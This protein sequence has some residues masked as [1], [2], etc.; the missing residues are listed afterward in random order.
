[1]E[2]HTW[3]AAHMERRTWSADFQVGSAQMRR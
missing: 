1:M 2:C 3:S